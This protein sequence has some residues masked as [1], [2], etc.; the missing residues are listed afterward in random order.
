MG[1]TAQAK[2]NL[3]QMAVA[4]GTAQPPP[5]TLITPINPSELT[6]ALE[7][8]IMDLLGRVAAGSSISILSEG[9]TQNGA[10]MLQGVFYPTKYF[11]TTTINWPGYLYDYWFYN[12][13]DI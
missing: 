8:I 1:L 9:Q 3:D 7:T 10:N 6:D 4:G 13:P 12:S 11:G 2:T 5:G